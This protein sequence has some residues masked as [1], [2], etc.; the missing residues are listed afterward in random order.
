MPRFAGRSS[1]VDRRR[2]RDR[3]RRGR[4]V[5]R[6]RRPARVPPAAA[7]AETPPPARDPRRPEIEI[8]C[9]PKT[10]PGARAGAGDPEPALAPGEP[11]VR[12]GRCRLAAVGRGAG[13][14]GAAIAGHAGPATAARGRTGKRRRQALYSSVRPGIPFGGPGRAHGKDHPSPRGAT[15]FENSTACAPLDRPSIEKCVQVRRR[16]TRI[17]SGVSGRRCQD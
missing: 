10:G 3:R 5:A 11:A 17:P 14:S 1:H 16:R 4:D 7:Y 13:L 12:A 8:P 2:P 15:V 9:R 6:S